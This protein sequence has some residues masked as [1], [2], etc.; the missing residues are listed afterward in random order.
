VAVSVADGRGVRG[1]L[2]QP[3][4]VRGG[5]DALALRARRIE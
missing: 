3:T 2:S 4:A 1:K 5:R